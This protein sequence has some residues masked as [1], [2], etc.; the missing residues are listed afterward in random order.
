MKT[1]RT[2][3]R[4]VRVL[5]GAR[6]ERVI[7]GVSLRELARA[8]KIPAITLS[9]FERGQSRLSPEREDARRI[10]LSRLTGESS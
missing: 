7:H 3:E 9:R 5:S 6:L 4:Q 2:T 8:A 10:A 1:R